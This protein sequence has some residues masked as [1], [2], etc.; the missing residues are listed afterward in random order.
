MPRWITQISPGSISITPNS[1]RRRS[2]PC[3]ATIRNSPSAL[4]T[5][6]LRIEAVTSST[7]A[8]MPVRV[9]ASP[10]VVMVRS[11]LTNVRFS[12]GIGIGPQRNWPIG[13]SLSSRAAGAVRINLLSILR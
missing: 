4:K 3:C 2:L 10:A 5:Y 11:P 12:S 13:K 8:A 9:S 7:C 1:V 6:S